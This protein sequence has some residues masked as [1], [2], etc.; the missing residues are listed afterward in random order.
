MVVSA[1]REMV[2]LFK[3]GMR[4]LLEEEIK[5]AGFRIVVE[6]GILLA[7]GGHVSDNGNIDGQVCIVGT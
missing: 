4:S 7:C 1:C 6:R 2:K 3:S 5:N